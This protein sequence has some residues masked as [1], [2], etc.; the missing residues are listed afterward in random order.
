MTASEVPISIAPEASRTAILAALTKEV[1]TQRR[2]SVDQRISSGSGRLDA[3]LPEQGFRRAT[4]VDRLGGGSLSSDPL[5]SDPLGS[6]E[7][8]GRRH[9]RSSRPAKPA[10]RAGCWS[11]SSLPAPGGFIRQ[12][13]R[14][15]GVVLG[16]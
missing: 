11:R 15:L 5:G 7:G 9:R 6:A 2:A 16:G 3:I 14:P 8:S 1:R 4:L 10:A 12:P 13:P